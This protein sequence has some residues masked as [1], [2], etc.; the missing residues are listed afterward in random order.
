M[1]LSDQ[2]MAPVV[3]LIHTPR[4][5]VRSGGECRPERTQPGGTSGCRTARPRDPSVRSTFGMTGGR[6]H[7]ADRTISGG[8]CIRMTVGVVSDKLTRR[9]YQRLPTRFRA[10]PPVPRHKPTPPAA[11]TA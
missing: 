7:S 2:A 9:V 5:I 8:G 11:A 4:E 3:I 6:G 10:Q 1:S